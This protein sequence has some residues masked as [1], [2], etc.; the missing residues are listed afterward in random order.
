MW[1]TLNNFLD[2]D[3]TIWGL[4]CS[5][6]IQKKISWNLWVYGFLPRALKISQG[7][8]FKT[9]GCSL[10]SFFS[11]GLITFTCLGFLGVFFR[12][13]F[14]LLSH[15]SPFVHLE[16]FKI[17]LKIE[18]TVN[19]NFPPVFYDLLDPDIGNI[20]TIIFIIWR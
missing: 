4:V 9:L 19:V 15:E 3:F 18:Y 14:H 12:N 6:I 20:S 17:G 13:N 5:R 8:S 7:I 11:L 1:F 10:G 2:S 16:C